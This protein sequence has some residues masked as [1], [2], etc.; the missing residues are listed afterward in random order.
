LIDIVFVHGLGGHCYRTWS[1]QE[2]PS[3]FWPGSWLPFEPHI[4][5]A[6]ILTFGYNSKWRGAQKNISTITDFAKNLLFEMRFAKDANGNDVDLGHRPIIFIV[7]IMG[8]L[9]VKKAYLLGIHDENYKE[10]V[11]SIS[12]VVFLSTPHRGTN[13]AETLNRIVSATFQSSKSFIADLQK[14][15]GL[16][17]ELNE[18]FR[19]L[20][21]GLSIWSFYETLATQIGPKKVMVLD[22][23]SSILGYP[24]E[25]SKPLEADHP[26]M[27]KY[28]SPA[29]SNYLS[30]KNAIQSL[31]ARL[32]QSVL[33]ASKQI[34]DCDLAAVDHFFKRSITCESDYNNIQHQKIPD[35]CIWFSELPVVASWLEATAKPKI[36]W[37]N[38]PPASG[39]SFLAA[40]VIDTLQKRGSSCQYF[41]CK[42]SH[43]EKRTVSG[44]LKSL[45]YQLAKEE[46][47][48]N[49]V[50]RA[51]SNGEN[52]L[53]A[54]DYST[55]WHNLFERSLF[56][57]AV[58][59]PLFWVID[60]LDECDNGRV[61]LR[62]LK[63][64]RD[65]R[66]RIRVLILSRNTEPIA[67][68]LGRIAKEI[69]VDT[70]ENCGIHHNTQDIERLVESEIQHIRGSENLKVQLKETIRTKSEG[71]FLWAKLV[72]EEIMDCHTEESIHQ[73]LHEVPTDMM[74]MYQRM[75]Q[76]IMASNKKSHMPLIRTIFKWVLCAQRPLKL[77]E[78]SVAIEP[79]YPGILDLKRTVRETCGQFIQV[80]K[81]DVV[82]ILHHTAREFLTQT[83]TSSLFIDC[84]IGH[85][86]MFLRTLNFL[87]DSQLGWKLTQNEATLRDNSPFLFYAAT[88]WPFHLKKC[89]DSSPTCLDALIRFLRS[90]GV[91]SWINFLA[92]INR[93]ETLV[94]ASKSMTN[95][96]NDMRRKDASKNPMLHRLN[97]LAVLES[98]SLDFL[99]VVG[100]FGHYL[101][102]DPTI[103]YDLVPA[104][105]PSDSTIGRQFHHHASAGVRLHGTDQT[106]WSDHLGRFGLPTNT[107]AWQ[108]LTAGKYVA[109]LASSNTVHVWDTVNFSECAAIADEEAIISVA[110]N[111]TGTRLATYGMKET[112]MWSLPENKLLG[113]T[114][115][116]SQSK[117]MTMIFHDKDR[118]LLSGG[119]DNVIRRLNL[120]ALE[121]GWQTL[122][123]KLLKDDNG[124][125][126]TVTASPMWIEFTADGKFVGV[127][128]RGAPLAIWRL[129]DA[130]CLNRCMRPASVKSNE[131]RQ[132]SSWFA[133]DRFTWNPVTAH[134]I[135]IY[136][137]GTMFKW[138][139]MTDELVESN[140]TADEVSASP[141]GKFFATS[142]SDG[143][144]RVWNFAYFTVIYQ[145]SSE[146]LVT[147]LCFSPS[148]RRFYDMRGGAINAWEPNCLLRQVEAE[149][150]SSDTNSEIQSLTS[151]SKFSEARIQQFEMATALALSPD[152][153]SYCIGH[154]DGR[155][156]LHSDDADIVEFGKF[157]NFLDVSHM[158]WS[159]NGE[160]VVS[161]DL[162]GEVQVTKVIVASETNE[163][164]TE[165]LPPKH[166]DNVKSTLLS[167]EGRHLLLVSEWGHKSSVFDLYDG[168]GNHTS[169]ISTD[170]NTVWTSHPLRSDIVLSFN[171]YGIEAFSWRTLDKLDKRAYSDSPGVGLN[172]TELGSLKHV[173]VGYDQKHILVCWGK[174][175]EGKSLNGQVDV[176]SLANWTTTESLPQKLQTTTL[177]PTV[178]SA[179]HVP[180]GI[181]GNSLFAYLDLDLWFC[182]YNI[183]GASNRSEVR[184]RHYF[185]PR[186]WVGGASLSNC[187]VSRDGTLFWPM[188]DRV[189]RIEIDFETAKVF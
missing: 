186:D 166:V 116:P 169:T 12:A 106:E 85:E 1:R 175:G 179:V 7:H 118:S 138:H 165:P 32:K 78:L 23:D 93:M 42:Q 86:Q 80:D 18:Q 58:M 35:T 181:L 120:D 146:D 151:T 51:L 125:N 177:A 67:N 157:Y 99:K 133:V 90:S 37:Y 83:R 117:P 84:P 121:S 119:D 62:C 158:S 95:F 108:L 97:D 63:S 29:D 155:I 48:F 178:S 73:V 103:I 61:F 109:A 31:V 136:R 188:E 141:N 43:Q 173:S 59:G 56:Q 50:I 87:S 182:T 171:V 81:A 139:P 45:A 24:S 94:K 111:S 20:A 5:T 176:I 21:P 57:S 4:D 180:L 25:I 19:H 52:E 127:S 110:M 144:I 14:S 53:E 162:A 167:A 135:G 140:R 88:S 22:K 123:E 161:V 41:F 145:L 153:Q 2:D 168:S 100:K 34:A 107:E 44:M 130:C 102:S 66:I 8:G 152:G 113:R 174:G 64:L 128:Y 47:E 159:A 54:A 163:S 184:H 28:S 10:L 105:S 104:F 33:R 126:G 9:V 156:F 137:V 16:I 75:E 30:V 13:L 55:L 11:A 69:T 148:G 115:N 187:A 17:E 40:S 114:I 172:N 6:R 15:S 65:S 92:V 132:S 150:H 124:P 129:D 82:S 91:L 74:E 36:L 185:I 101:L 170:P 77:S 149:D 164:E 96:S 154:E 131:R 3:V 39:K 60:G 46:P 38:A 147:G 134:I 71:N 143:C 79:S 122:N 89:G 160:W 76:T 70:V 142:S 189:L 72:L 27:C 98:W 26:N 49:R 112:K 68:E 183:L